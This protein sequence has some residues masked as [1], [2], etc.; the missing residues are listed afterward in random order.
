MRS[1]SEPSSGWSSS[2]FQ[3]SDPH[4]EMNFS[5]NATAY[6][7]A[8]ALSGSSGDAIASFLLGIVDSGSISTTNFISSQK[9]TWG[10]YVQDDWK[11]T[12]KLTLNLG[13]RYE[14]FLAHL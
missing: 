10:F 3:F 7:G 1:S 4:G 14:L 11:V 9:Q 8:G 6:P 5:N 2:P 12:P 13:M